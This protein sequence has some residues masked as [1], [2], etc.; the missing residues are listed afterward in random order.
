MKVISWDIGI[1]NLAYCVMS[2]DYKIHEWDIITLQQ[3][4][5]KI[6]V[7]LLTQRLL[8]ILDDRFLD[9]SDFT[10]VL[11]ENQPSMK[12]PVMKS[13]QNI[14]YTFFHYIKLKHKFDY[15]VKLV[16]ATSK[17]KVQSQVQIPDTILKIKN[18]YAQKKK[19]AVFLCEY[20][21]SDIVTNTGDFRSYFSG[22][23]KKDDLADCL[24]YNVWFIQQNYTPPPNIDI[25]DLTNDTEF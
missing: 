11:I 12:N 24:L 19:R 15:A 6:N 7:D 10:H 3:D 18:K 9:R 13:I 2:G 17:L 21:L 8:Q 25:I 1:K 23:K 22:S 16:S 5:K 14:I 20:L 4:C